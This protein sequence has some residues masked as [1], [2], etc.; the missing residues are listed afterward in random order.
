MADELRACTAAQRAACLRHPF[1]RGIG[2]GSLPPS[3]FARWVVQDWLYLQT[4]LEVLSALARQ[5]PD[6]EARARWE[7]LVA[8]TRD[9]ELALHRAFAA[10]F[11]LSEADL[12]GATPWPATVAYTRFLAEAAATDYATGVAALLPC[13]VGYVELARALSRGEPPNDPRYADWIRTYADP[14]F[15]EA[16][17]WMEAELKRTGVPAAVLRPTWVAGADHELAFWDQL[18]DGA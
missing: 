12:D 1:V 13:G 6:A 18:W 4:Y 11:G 2:D 8:L 16:V 3:F 7:A 15:A 14:S 9:E 17:A 5:A 10:R